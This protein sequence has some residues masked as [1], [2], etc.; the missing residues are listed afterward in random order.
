M[1]DKEMAE[2]LVYR[3]MNAPQGMLTG[4]FTGDLKERFDVAREAGYL[5]E[6]PAAAT[7]RYSTGF[8]ASEAGRQFAVRNI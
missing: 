5:E 1:T 7:G 4:G 3:V 6:V 8:R 2:F